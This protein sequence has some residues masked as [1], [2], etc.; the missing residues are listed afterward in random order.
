MPKTFISKPEPNG[1]ITSNYTEKRRLFAYFLR[2]FSFMRKLYRISFYQILSVLSTNFYNNFWKTLELF[3]E[4]FS[5]CKLFNFFVSCKQRTPF[6][7]RKNDFYK[8]LIPKESRISFIYLKSFSLT[9][10]I[11]LSFFILCGRVNN[12]RPHLTMW[13]IGNSQIAFFKIG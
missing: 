2:I 7:V 9:E 5:W 8:W 4:F 6:F 13:K 3:L 11:P 12:I 10:W 1:I